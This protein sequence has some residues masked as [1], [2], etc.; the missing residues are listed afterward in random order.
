MTVCWHDEAKVEFI[1]AAAYYEEQT[2]NLGSRFGTAL[3]SAIARACSNPTTPR[4]FHT[5]FR[6]VGLNKF[7]YAAVYRL[8]DEDNLQIIA[9]MHLHRKP[10]YWKSRSFS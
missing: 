3:E 10:G 8:L 2:E 5:S 4:T 1:E 9:V 7:P 6:K